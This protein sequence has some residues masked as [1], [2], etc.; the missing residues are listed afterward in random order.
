[1]HDLFPTFPLEL[2]QAFL[3]MQDPSAVLPVFPKHAFSPMHF[4]R[5]FGFFFLGQGG[6]H[7]HH[8]VMGKSSVKRGSAVTVA[9]RAEEQLGVRR[10]AGNVGKK[11]D[12][13]K[14]TTDHCLKLLCQ[15][16]D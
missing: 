2:I 10:A 3:A 4:P 13:Y 7:G 11:R 16:K 12:S 5:L 6:H 14:L 8:T 1:M 9:R 15:V